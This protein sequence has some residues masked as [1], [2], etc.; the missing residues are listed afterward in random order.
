MPIPNSAAQSVATTACGEHLSCAFNAEIRLRRGIL[1][2]SVAA[3]NAFRPGTAARESLQNRRFRASSAKDRLRR[4]KKT[5][6]TARKNA[7]G[8]REPAALK[9]KFARGAAGSSRPRRRRQS[10]VARNVRVGTTACRRN[11]MIPSSTFEERMRICVACP[12][13]AGACVKGHA[14]SSPMGCPIHKFPPIQAAGYAPDRGGLKPVT[15][16]SCCD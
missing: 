2:R 15:G 1:A 8:W 7:V 11:V 9:R 3:R 13:W 6:S 4:R 12:F 14:P 10:V 5:P 16:S